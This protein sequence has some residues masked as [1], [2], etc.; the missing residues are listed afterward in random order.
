MPLFTFQE[1][2]TELDKYQNLKNFDTVILQNCN[3]SN[4]LD[5]NLMEEYEKF[6]D[7]S[8][9]INYAYQNVDR[10]YTKQTW[11]YEDKKNS[12][13]LGI[14]LQFKDKINKLNMTIEQAIITLC[15]LDQYCDLDTFFELPDRYLTIRNQA[16]KYKTRY[17]IEILSKTKILSVKHRHNT[18]LVKLNRKLL[19]KDPYMQKALK[20]FWT[21]NE[22]A[23]YKCKYIYHSTKYEDISSQVIAKNKRE[24]FIGITKA[25]NDLCGSFIM[26]D[27]TKSMNKL[28]GQRA[29]IDYWECPVHIISDA[30]NISQ[31]EVTE[32]MHMICKKTNYISR[33]NKVY[34]NSCTSDN[35]YNPNYRQENPLVKYNTTELESTHP[36]VTEFSL[37]VHTKNFYS[38]KTYKNIKNKDKLY[39]SIVI[40]ELNDMKISSYDSAFRNSTEID[41]QDTMRKRLGKSESE[42]NI[43]LYSWA[44]DIID[45]Y[46]YNQK[47]KHKNTKYTP[48]LKIYDDADLNTCVNFLIKCKDKL[49][50]C[51]DS[52]LNYYLK[53]FK[54]IQ[55]KVIN[56]LSSIKKSNYS[57]YKNIMDKYIKNEK[58]LSVIRA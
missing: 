16:S 41:I 27:Y 30:L 36:V 31:K 18:I 12:E 50:V 39:K 21:N 49:A 5:N 52:D 43:H 3:D 54:E 32:Y 10:V 25:Y 11:N 19:K 24:M 35:Y 51:Q 17:L 26:N 2:E 47:L 38:S 22:K 55:T 29:D 42:E 6:C 34:V 44:D 13:V 1:S 23:L 48:R 58:I 14:L 45:L 53:K 20:R 40:N 9:N 4:N 46:K 8:R 15:A 7:E 37:I 33:H 28:Y 56:L 57:A